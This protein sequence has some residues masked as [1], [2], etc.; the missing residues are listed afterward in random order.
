MN[1]DILEAPKG[2]SGNMIKIKIGNDVISIAEEIAA[3]F[4]ATSGETAENYC[5]RLAQGFSH[6][7][8]AEDGLI[9]MRKQGKVDSYIEA[10]MS[11]ENERRLI[12]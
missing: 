8:T 6:D 10:L 11:S 2:K 9:R 7:G 5:K 12:N 1:D 4:E 3:F